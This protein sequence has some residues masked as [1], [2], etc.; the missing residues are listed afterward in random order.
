MPNH[1]VNELIFRAA[2]H[3]AWDQILRATLNAEDKVDFG[4]LLPMPFNMWWGN[5]GA[6]HE[7]AF[8]RTALAWCTEHW[9][10]KWNA[11]QTHP[12]ERSD[13][14]MILRFDTAWRPPYPWLAAIF[15]IFKV[16]FDHN[17][18]DEGAARG[19]HGV[20]DYAQTENLVGKPWTETPAD[21]ALQ[22]HLHKL[23]WG[24]EEFPPEEDEAD[25]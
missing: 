7:K 2:D 18:L 23:R 3:A 9:G 19:V 25:G 13:E 16:S 10:T 5:V 21:D 11:Y 1:V 24:V 14:A 20:F 15:N 22:R 6:A 12:V 8:N 17:W 4:L